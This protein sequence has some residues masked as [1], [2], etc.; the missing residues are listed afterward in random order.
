[1]DEAFRDGVNVAARRA[2]LDIEVISSQKCSRSGVLEVPI[3]K[4]LPFSPYLVLRS[5]IQLEVVN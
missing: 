1:M 2:R 3:D 5:A 4:L